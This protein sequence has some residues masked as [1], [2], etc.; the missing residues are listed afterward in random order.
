MPITREKIL[1]HMRTKT[2]RPLLMKEL[3]KDLGVVRDDKSDFKD[4]VRDLMHDGEVIKIRGNRY[5]LPEKMSLIVGK[6]TVHP[7]GYGFVVPEKKDGGEPEPDVYINNRNLMGAM[8]GDKVVARIESEKPG[9][10]QEGKVIRILDRANERIV[11]RFESGRGFGVIIPTNPRLVQEFYVPPKSMGDAK[12]GEMVVADIVAYPEA[13]RS[14]EVRVTKVLGMAGEPKLDTDLI[15]EEHG[16]AT[17]FS[18]AALAEAKSA[19]QKVTAPMMRG[20]RDLRGM[21]TVTIDGETARDFDDAVSV[22]PE[23]GGLIR[24]FVSIADVANYVKEGT[25]LDGDAR[26]R[27]TSVY[28]PDRVL[29]MLPEELSNGIC[30]LNAGVERL[31]LTAEMVFNEKGERVGYDIYESVIKS[32]Q[33]MTYTD[34]SA[35][36]EK[37]DQNTKDR[38]PELVPDFML[39]KELMGRLNAMRRRR[40]SIDFDLPEPQVVINLRGQT[41]AIIK[42]ERNE[43]HKLIEELMLAANEAVALH[44]ESHGVPLLYRV[45]EE[46]DEDKIAALAELVTSFGLPWPSGGNIR[47]KHLAQLLTKIEGR[48]EERFLNTVILRSMKL[49]KYSPENKGHFGLASRCYC[50]FTSPIRRYPDL[51]VHRAVKELLRAGELP[52]A[53]KSA[54]AA[55]LP[56]LGQHTSFMEREAEQAERQVVELKKLQFMVSK[57]GAEFDGFI[58]GMTAFGFF[59]ELEEYFVEGLVRLTSLYDDY[60]TYEEKAHALKGAHTGRTHRLGDKVTVIVERVDLERRQMDFKLVLPESERGTRGMRGWQASPGRPAGPAG[61]GP[62]KPARTKHG[63]GR[64]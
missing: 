25:A 51:T 33:R 15:I 47:P 55:S 58:T 30:S 26:E 54:L 52:A 8:H 41:T 48:P 28:F 9:G 40:G 39:M 37:D 10:R 18:P 22:A 14:A 3:M 56:G 19:P 34:V 11:G 46:P 43:A 62:A 2:Y 16:L 38:F 21:K 31:T 32:D 61:P 49:A 57:V 4:A 44:I 36:I 64:R 29:P 5:G 13:Y 63:K 27:A 45:H 35:I 6:L 59:V 7:D 23:K 53:R 42:S 20:R 60:Y 17:E 24:L 12:D 50:H 1:A